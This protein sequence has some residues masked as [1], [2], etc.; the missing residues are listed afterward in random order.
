MKHSFSNG[1]RHVRLEIQS[2]CLLHLLVGESRK[3]AC[4]TVHEIVS[5]GW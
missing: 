2:S 5:W 3:L 1:S 4:H